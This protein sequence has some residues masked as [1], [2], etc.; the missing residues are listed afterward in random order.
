MLSKISQEYLKQRLD[1]DPE[2]GIFVW[3]P[4]PVTDKRVDKAWNTKCAG[5]V[6]NHTFKNG[7]VYI[8]LDGERYLAH[9][10]AWLYMT[11][12]WPTGFLDHRDR[13]PENNRISNIREA[14]QSQNMANTKMTKGSIGARGVTFRKDRNK[15]RATITFQHKRFYIGLFDTVEEASAAYKSAAIRVFG[16]FA[17]LELY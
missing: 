2:T 5:K 8:R 11:G 7:Y 9:R 1:Y 17:S 6:A 14:S 3:K 16:D 10:L 13:N 12:T 15:Y 4:K